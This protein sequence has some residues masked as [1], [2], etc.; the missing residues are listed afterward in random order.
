MQ[1]KLHFQERF[2]TN[3]WFLE[4]NVAAGAELNQRPWQTLHHSCPTWRTK[5]LQLKFF[6]F[7]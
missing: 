4:S 1:V 3:T 5:P 2:D 7:N 6:C